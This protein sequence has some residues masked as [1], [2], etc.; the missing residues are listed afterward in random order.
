MADEQGVDRAHVEQAEHLG[1]V[2]DAGQAVG[3]QHAGEVDER[4]GRGRHP[5]FVGVEGDDV[6]L[7]AQG[8]AAVD[9]QRGGGAAPAG[10]EDVDRP[11][12][13]RQEVVHIGRGAVPDRAAGGQHRRHQPT[14]PGQQAGPHGVDAS[15]HAVQTPL[16]TPELHRP[17]AD[18]EPMQL[19]G[20]DRALLAPG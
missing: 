9:A 13:R 8:P 7:R 5:Q 15:V 19:R 10:G 1:A 12:R 3:G 2:D 11:G 14:A 4:A 18:P 20:R 17:A 6:A 16:L